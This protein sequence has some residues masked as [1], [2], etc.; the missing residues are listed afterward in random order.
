MPSDPVRAGGEPSDNSNVGNGDNE[1]D[2][3][4]AE[5][6]AKSP[7]KEEDS[8]KL[9]PRGSPEGHE[10]RKSLTGTCQEKVRQ[11]IIK[12]KFLTDLPIH[13]IVEKLLVKELAVEI[14]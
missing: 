14:Q 9:F 2:E 7:Q 10:R 1:N 6:S 11:F 3:R 5:Q 8:G 12:R 13:L 4:E